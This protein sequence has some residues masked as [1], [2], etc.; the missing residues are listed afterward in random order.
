M[1]TYEDNLKPPFKKQYKW[2]LGSN[3]QKAVQKMGKGIAAAAAS[4]MIWPLECAPIFLCESERLSTSSTCDAVSRN[5]S[6]YR[7]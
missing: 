6:R 7:N 3:Y 2:L 5:K 1:G 4:G